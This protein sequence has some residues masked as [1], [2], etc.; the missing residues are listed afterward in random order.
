M[1]V[2]HKAE[3]ESSNYTRRSVLTAAGTVLSMGT[4]GLAGGTRRRQE[5]SGITA[6][7]AIVRPDG[8]EQ[9]QS[10]TGFFIHVSD[11]I[12]PLQ[13]QVSERCGSIDWDPQSTLQYDAVLI[14]RQEERH[15]SYQ[16][17]LYVPGR[18]NLRGGELFVVNTE[19]PCPSGYVGLEIEQIG[20]QFVVE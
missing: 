14:N 15:T 16:T 8:V 6:P 9:D 7:A 17:P 12:N 3:P 5:E 19:E 11:R 13:A 18:I 2:R 20:A 1:M 4:T 10:L